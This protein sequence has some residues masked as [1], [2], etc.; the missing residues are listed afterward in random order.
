MYLPSIS[1]AWAKQG[2][3]YFSQMAIP[4]F[5]NCAV[6]DAKCILSPFYFATPQHW[7]LLSFDAAVKT[8]YLDHGLKLSPPRDTVVVTKNMP[9]GFELLSHKVIFKEENWNQPKL[10]FLLLCFNMPRQTTTKDGSASCG[11]GV[12]KNGTCIPPFKWEFENMDSLRKL[13]FNGKARGQF[14]IWY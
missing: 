12:I 2:A 10:H 13:L 11:I 4:F 6:Q 7:G 8:V 5:V 14:M 3:H 1:Q 9:R